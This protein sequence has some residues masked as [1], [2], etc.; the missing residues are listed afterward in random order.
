MY[1]EARSGA[2]IAPRQEL[3][4]QYRGVRSPC[5]CDP[6]GVTLYFFSERKAE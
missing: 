5:V 4:N 3:K 1:R 2:E 6:N